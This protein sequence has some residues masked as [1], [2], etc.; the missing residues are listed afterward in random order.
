MAPIQ[1]GTWF[2]GALLK[3]DFFLIRTLS[4]TVDVDREELVGEPK[5]LDWIGV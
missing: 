5:R 3:F 1:R 4:Q 2:S